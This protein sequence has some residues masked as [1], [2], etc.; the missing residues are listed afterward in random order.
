MQQALQPEKDLA[1][2][3]LRFRGPRGSNMLDTIPSIHY[4]LR[5]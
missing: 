5:Y 1:E 4:R 2:E 3:T